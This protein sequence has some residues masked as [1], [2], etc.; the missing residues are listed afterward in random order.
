[1]ANLC[2]LMFSTCIEYI[3]AKFATKILQMLMP[4][5]TRHPTVWLG[6]Q[7]HISECLNIL[8]CLSLSCSKSVICLQSGTRCFR[9]VWYE[10]SPSNLAACSQ[11]HSAVHARI[12]YLQEKSKPRA[13]H[14]HVLACN[15]R[16]P[17]QTMLLCTWSKLR[18]RCAWFQ[19][20]HWPSAPK[21]LPDTITVRFPVRMSPGNAIC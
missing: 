6:F 16:K 1:M 17:T 5:A 18:A 7:C 3:E 12:V 14:S 9:W 19:F 20:M 2:Q 10:V 8:L 13:A 11:N 21:P 15:G 4:M